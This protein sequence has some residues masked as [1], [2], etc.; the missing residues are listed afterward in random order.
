MKVLRASSLTTISCVMNSSGLLVPRARTS[1]RPVGS[2]T[3]E[4]AEQVFCFRNQ[5]E[6]AHYRQNTGL[7]EAS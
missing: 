5:L 2:G 7:A 1:A 4:A 6:Q 3:T